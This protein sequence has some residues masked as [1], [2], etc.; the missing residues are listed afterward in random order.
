MHVRVA[1]NLEPGLTVEDLTVDYAGSLNPFTTGEASVSYTVRNT[2]NTR[3]S[4]GQTVKLS[5]PWGM[6][7]V[8][9]GTMDPVPELLPDETWTV[10]A[11]AAGV[12]PTFRLTATSLVT[13]SVPT[14]TDAAP[15]TDPVRT[16]AGTWAVP[17]TPLGLLVVMVG[18]LVTAIIASRRRN[19]QRALAE[20]ARVQH[21]VTEALRGQGPAA[22]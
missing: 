3:L 2:G 11:P 10:S 8:T 6:W 22:G 7:P 13:P 18:G 12:L 14:M 17:W 16:T 20:E 21:A 19:A 5:G 15:E 4:A 9:A 1:G